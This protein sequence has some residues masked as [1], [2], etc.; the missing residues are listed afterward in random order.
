MGDCTRH[1]TDRPGDRIYDL[2]FSS[3]VRYGW[4]YASSA[5]D[6]VIPGENV[7]SRNLLLSYPNFFTVYTTR[8]TSCHSLDM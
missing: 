8:K 6:H 5:S 3:P 1:N 7:G 2:L 4:S